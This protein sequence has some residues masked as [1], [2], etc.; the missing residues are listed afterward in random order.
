MK[1]AY[2]LLGFMLGMLVTAIL[3]HYGQARV[4]FQKD[5]QVAAGE[6]KIEMQTPPCD[7]HNLEVIWPKESGNPTTIE[8]N[9]MPVPER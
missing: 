2:C 1:I 9:L 4:P 8:C 5:N 7:V 3:A 6:W